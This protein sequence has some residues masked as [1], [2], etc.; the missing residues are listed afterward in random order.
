MRGLAV[1]AATGEDEDDTITEEAAGGTALDWESDW[2]S[3]VNEGVEDNNN[4]RVGGE[5]DSAGRGDDDSGREGGGDDD[6]S[7]GCE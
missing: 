6:A 2:L 3:L 1:T 7:G 4:N 5:E